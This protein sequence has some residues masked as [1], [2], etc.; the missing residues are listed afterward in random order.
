MPSQIFM[1]NRVICFT[2]LLSK[3]YPISLNSFFVSFFSVLYTFRVLF[4]RHFEGL[5]GIYQPEASWTARWQ[6]FNSLK[7]GL[8]ALKILEE[9]PGDIKAEL[10]Q[11]K[12]PY[13]K[14][15]TA[16]RQDEEYQPGGE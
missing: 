9:L 15:D 12:T 7:P 8:Y 11:S 3:S 6:G 16:T 1:F 13:L 4:R 5:C 2:I 14:E 10:D